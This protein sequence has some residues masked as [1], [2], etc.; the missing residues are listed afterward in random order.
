MV[1][2]DQ[3]E[4]TGRAEAQRFLDRFGQRCDQM[5][6]VEFAGQGIVSRQ[7]HEMLVAG[8]A[9]VVDPDNALRARRP[10]IGA[11]KPAAGFL[12][13]QH[14]GGG[15]GAH[16]VFDPIEQ[17]LAATLHGRMTERVRPDRA[18]RLDQPGKLRAACQRCRRDIRE[19]RARIIAPDNRVGCDVPREGRLAERS[20]DGRNWRKSR[21]H[22]RLVSGHR[23]VIP[24]HKDRTC[25]SF[26]T[27]LSC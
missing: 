16:T 10:A 8:A 7:P 14:R 19:N 3:H 17:A 24:G 11:R 4:G 21:C 5:G 18:L 25:C 12:D 6:A 2:A 20:Q 13:P 23:R 1:D 26:D 15:R 22:N 27:S 9:F